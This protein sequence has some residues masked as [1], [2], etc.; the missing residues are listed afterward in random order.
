MNSN[1]A[2]NSRKQF[3]EMKML[4]KQRKKGS[5]TKDFQYKTKNLKHSIHLVSLYQKN[6]EQKIASK[7]MPQS[8][9]NH[10]LEHPNIEK[11][12]THFYKAEKLY[13]SV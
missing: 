9:M 4:K 11:Y 5:H 1:A 7:S 2:A 12:L 8:R 10:L 6:R 3:L 13:C